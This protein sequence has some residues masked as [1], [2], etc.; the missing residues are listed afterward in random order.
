MFGFSSMVMSTH[1]VPY[2][3]HVSKICNLGQKYSFGERKP[4]KSKQTVG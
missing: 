2:E 3:L 4:S 1:Y